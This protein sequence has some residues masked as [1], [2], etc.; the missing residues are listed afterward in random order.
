MSNPSAKILDQYIEAMLYLLFEERELSIVFQESFRV[1]FEC[2]IIYIICWY[3]SS[4]IENDSACSSVISD[5]SSAVIWVQRYGSLLFVLSLAN[6]LTIEDNDDVYFTISIFKYIF[7][8]NV[9][10]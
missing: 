2:S 7:C 9:Y 6:T 4:I 5:L 10:L 8:F 3:N 1:Q